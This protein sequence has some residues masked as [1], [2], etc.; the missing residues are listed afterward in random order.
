MA[1]LYYFKYP[2][3]YSFAYATYS[4]HHSPFVIHC[5]EH[6]GCNGYKDSQINT[7]TLWSMKTRVK[8]DTQHKSMVSHAYIPQEAHA[9]HWQQCGEWS[10]QGFLGEGA[11]THGREV[12]VGFPE[13]TALVVKLDGCLCICKV[14]RR[15]KVGFPIKRQN[16]GKD[17]EVWQ[18]WKVWENSKS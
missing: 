15:G 7:L 3:P 4:S 12:K 5:V 1:L 14:D 2:F 11:G 17:S 13:K 16:V 8:T 6:R 10:F 18:A 9:R